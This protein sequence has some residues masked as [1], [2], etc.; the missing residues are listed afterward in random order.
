[1]TRIHVNPPSPSFI[2][3]QRQS[4]EVALFQ[5]FSFLKKRGLYSSTRFTIRTRDVLQ[6]GVGLFEANDEMITPW[7]RFS[8]SYIQR[9]S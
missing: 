1:M 7:N 3:R 5:I 4:V 2:N 8:G 6:V 9:A